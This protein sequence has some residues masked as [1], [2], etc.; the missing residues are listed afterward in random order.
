[1]L[2]GIAGCKGDGWRKDRGEGG[3]RVECTDLFGYKEGRVGDGWG[4]G[5]VL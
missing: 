1:M 3:A 2:A 5:W 4:G